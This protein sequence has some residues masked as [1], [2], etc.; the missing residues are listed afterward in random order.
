MKTLWTTTITAL[1]VIALIAMA[2][3]AHANGVSGGSGD[4]GDLRLTVGNLTGIFEGGEPEITFVAPNAM[5]Q[6]EYE[7]EFERVF[8]FQ[9]SSGDQR[10]QSS[11]KLAI[12]DLEQARWTNN[13]FQEITDSSG[14]RIGLSITF[15]IDPSTLRIDR[16]SDGGQ[17]TVP[18]TFDMQLVVKAFETP[19]TITLPNGR[20]FDISGT[21]IK[22][23]IVIQDWPFIGTSSSMLAVQIDL[24]S[25]VEQFEVEDSDGTVSVDGSRP[26]DQATAEHNIDDDLNDVEEE[27]RLSN[28]FLTTSSTIGFFRFVDEATV[29]SGSTTT[30]VPV[31]ASFK[32]EVEDDETEFKLYLAYPR[33]TGKLEHDPSFAITSGGTP[34]LFFVMGGAAVAGLVTVLAIRRRHPTIDHETKPLTEAGPTGPTSTFFLYRA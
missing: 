27:V 9:D 24:D 14:N 31:T 32:V 19:Q 18:S 3:V 12:A 15:R 2:P 25:E 17:V 28:G 21:E 26:E 29:T 34:T 20:S 6:V 5:G 13:G 16:A 4:N 33:F 8:E 23:D 10:F 7:V 11:E 1:S 22:I 30:T